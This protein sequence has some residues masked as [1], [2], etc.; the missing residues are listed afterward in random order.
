MKI[1]LI[2]F[3]LILACSSSTFAQIKEVKEEVQIRVPPPPPPPTPLW[4]LPDSIRKKR[5]LQHRED[6]KKW[7]FPD[8]SCDGK[9]E[10]ERHYC[11]QKKMLEFIYKN[12]KYP[13]EARDE[14]IAG[15]VVINFTIG[16][17]GQIFD[18]KIVKGIRSDCDEE[19]LRVV[20]MMPDWHR[21]GSRGALPKGCRYRVPIK[22]KLD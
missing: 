7:Q 3:T 8:S 22:F 18:A 13:Q 1:K 20:N 14:G 5:A 6:C 11:S 2:I 4:A 21:R 10:A 15:T 19:A 9:S 17:H 12:L 16:S